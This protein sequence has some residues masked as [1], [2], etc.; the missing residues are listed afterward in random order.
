MTQVWNFDFPSF[1]NGH[2]KKDLQKGSTAKAGR[3]YG[4]NNHLLMGQECQNQKR[5][6]RLRTITCPG[7][8]QF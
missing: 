5:S 2:V 8:S 4:E 7:T 1:K 3:R 6:L